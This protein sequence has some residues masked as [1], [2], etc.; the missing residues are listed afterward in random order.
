MSK[1]GNSRSSNNRHLAKLGFCPDRARL[2]ESFYQK[3]IELM[4][5]YAC[6]R[7]S[8]HAFKLHIQGGL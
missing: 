3:S 1:L 8:C 7:I 5:M 6:I 4:A 2:T